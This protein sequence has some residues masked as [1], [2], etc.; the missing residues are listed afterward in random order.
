[1]VYFI[2]VDHDSFQQGGGSPCFVTCHNRDKY[3]LNLIW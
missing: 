2:K 3:L 1:M